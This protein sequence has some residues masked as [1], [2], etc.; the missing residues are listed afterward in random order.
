MKEA[1]KL[2]REVSYCNWIEE[3]QKEIWD[4][5]NKF[6]LLSAYLNYLM[7]GNLIDSKASSIG[8]IPFDKKGGIG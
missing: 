4:K 3:N 6:V 2:Q 5:T 8:H 7:T 1:V